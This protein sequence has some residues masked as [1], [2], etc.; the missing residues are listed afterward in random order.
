MGIREF[1]LAAGFLTGSHPLAERNPC[2]ICPKVDV[3][4]KFEKKFV[5]AN[6]GLLLC[7]CQGDF[8]GRKRCTCLLQ[9]GKY[10]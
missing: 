7:C 9:L 8:I 4:R 10:Q 2:R 1:G 3:N 6:V 5:V